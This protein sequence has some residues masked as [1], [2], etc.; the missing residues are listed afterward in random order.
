MKN[1]IIPILTILTL[2]INFNSC[3]KPEG[4]YPD[5]SDFPGCVVQEIPY[6]QKTIINENMKWKDLIELEVCSMVDMSVIND[7]TA[8]NGQYVNMGETGELACIYTAE[9][10]GYYDIHIAYRAIESD[11]VQFLKV[12]GVDTPIGFGYTTTWQE[13]IQPFYLRKGINMLGMSPSWGFQ[14]VDYFAIGPA[15]VEFK[16]TPNHITFYKEFGIFVH[17]D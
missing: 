17:D 14:D 10:A 6:V 7:S 1:T 13:V 11:R 15:E 2:I 4:I 9:N 12:N 5:Q 8:S 3:S 16:F